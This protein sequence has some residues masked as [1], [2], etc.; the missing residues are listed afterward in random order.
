[1]SSDDLDRIEKALGIKLP[2]AYRLFVD[3]FPIPCWKGNSSQALWDD[4]DSLIEENLLLRKGGWNVPAWPISTYS[5]GRGDDGCSYA[6][7]I[8]SPWG[9]VRYF[10]NSVYTSLGTSEV[11]P[12]FKDW[13]SAYVESVKRDMPEF[14]ID[15][16]G[17]PSQYETNVMDAAKGCIKVILFSIGFVLVFSLIVLL[18]STARGGPG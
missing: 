13:A 7:R 16:E 14:G 11:V 10:Q 8:D 3:P 2:S 6:I 9:E 12:R 5:M 1:M 15:P 18:I 4:A 17:P